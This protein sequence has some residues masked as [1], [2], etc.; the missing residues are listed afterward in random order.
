MRAVVILALLAVVGCSRTPVPEAPQQQP[1]AEQK[2]VAE[3]A[4]ENCIHVVVLDVRKSTEE[5]GVD[6]LI[7]TLDGKF[8][9]RRSRC[10]FFGNVG[11]KFYYCE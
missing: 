6:S 1:V 4:G 2:P 7:E 9:Y 11:D 8:N 5:C 3:T 10:G